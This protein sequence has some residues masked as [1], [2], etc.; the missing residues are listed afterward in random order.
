MKPEQWAW[1]S[2]M[3]SGTI[4]VLFF[5]FPSSLGGWAMIFI[6][7]YQLVATL[8]GGDQKLGHWSMLISGITILIFFPWPA[9]S[10][11]LGLILIG[12][13]QLLGQIGKK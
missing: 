8:P 9:S 6:S 5:A 3:I 1:L 7:G 11:A 13:W 10:G 12:V 2:M 4:L